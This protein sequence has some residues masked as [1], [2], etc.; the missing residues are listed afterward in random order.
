MALVLTEEQDMLKTSA[1]DFLKE[2]SP[3][4]ALRKLR[5]DNNPQGYDTKVWQEMVEAGW[6]SLII[7]EKYGGLSYGFVG[8]G[9]VLEETGR[10]LTAS[11]L[12][13]TALL[14]ATTLILAGS[15]NQKETLLPQIAEGKLV[16]AMALEE[17]NQHNPSRIQMTAEDE[18]D[19]YLLNGKKLFVLDGHIANK[20]IVVARIQGG[21][22]E[23]ISLFLVD[24]N[25][26]GVSITKRTMMDS[27]NAA[28]VSFK[29]VE[30]AAS[31]VIGDEGRGFVVLE[32]V[33]DIAR[34]GLSAEML[35]TV[36]EAFERTIA[37]L[38]QRQ[39]FG[40]PIGVFQG[41]QHRAAQM[42]NEVELCKS[43]VIKALQ[44]VDAN[45]KN[46]ARTASLTKAKLGET[47]KL[48]TNEAVQM[49]GG[50][51]MTD[52]EE[53]GF[54]LKRARVAQ[55]TF[56]DSNYHLDRFARLNDF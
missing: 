38:K 28:T 49:F 48:V 11:P 43:L 23:G 12:I 47:I 44:A 25:A 1:R 29:N 32:K 52:D 13:S 46:L 4:A 41:L 34:I 30:V 33:L 9:Q 3:V 17:S 21:S 42:Y 31:D 8:L 15:Q 6:T 20:F 27:R 37:Y 5:D 36:S 39:Q 22:H 51:G 26:E 7:P 19:K 14:G 2:K 40:V 45:D 10:T 18:G 16:L 50:I 54:F 35:G 53:I 56:G 55:H 24:S